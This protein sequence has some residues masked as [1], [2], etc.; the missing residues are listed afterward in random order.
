MITDY[1][2]DFDGTLFN[3]YPRMT[4]AV[5]RGLEAF[6]IS[7]EY[8]WILRNM[9]VSLATAAKAVEERYGIK[10]DQVVGG[11]RFHAEDEGI[12]S[13]IPYNGA[14]DALRAVVESGGKNYLYTHRNITALQTLDFYGIQNLF[15]DAITA[16]DGFPA[17]PAPDALIHLIK[18]HSLCQQSCVMIGDRPI[19]LEAGERAGMQAVLFDPE[20]FYIDYPAKYRFTSFSS[21]LDKLK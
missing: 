3:T 6:G 4:R 5:L 2:W 1:F 15:H 14:I 17:K 9:K 19:D 18:K 16:E 12:E 7:A 21:L 11:Y 8:S 20:E 13:I 10:A